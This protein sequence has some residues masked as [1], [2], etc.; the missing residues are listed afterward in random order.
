M[1]LLVG[2]IYGLVAFGIFFIAVSMRN[3]RLDAKQVKAIVNEAEIIA[4][5]KLRFEQAQ[6][7]S[8]LQL[9]LLDQAY[10][11]SK[12]VAHSKYKNNLIRRIEEIEKEKIEIFRSIVKDGI[13][14]YLQL[15]GPDGQLEKVRMS[16]AI[17]RAEEGLDI[18]PLEEKPEQKT[19]T[20]SSQDDASNV[21]DFTKIRE[22]RNGKSSSPTVDKS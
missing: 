15:A 18:E 8:A 17:K 1:D 3:S 20:N 10:Q 11:P 19:E 12:N 5:V 21:I 14:P 2:I 9:D 4:S 13:D 7:L 6:E 22:K 16:E